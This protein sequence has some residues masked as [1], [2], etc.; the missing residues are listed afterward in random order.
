MGQP[1]RVLY[2]EIENI[3]VNYQITSSIR[4]GVDSELEDVDASEMGAI[5]V[6]QELV[7]VAGDIND[8][9]ASPR[10]AQHLLHKIIVGLRPVPIRLEGPTIDD[11]ADEIDDLRI[12]TSEK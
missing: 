11:V 7:M 5:V 10:P 6:S 9:R 3:A 2:H 8:F 12:M 1:A 4:S